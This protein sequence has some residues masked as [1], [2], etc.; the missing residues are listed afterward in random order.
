[1]RDDDPYEVRATASSAGP[2]TSVA[3]RPGIE[4]TWPSE[5]Y[6]ITVTLAATS[7]DASMPPMFSRSS[8]SQPEVMDATSTSSRSSWS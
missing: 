2:S 3:W 1:M 8:D 6:S 5:R 7:A 4:I